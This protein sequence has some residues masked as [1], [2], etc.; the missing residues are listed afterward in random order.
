MAKAQQEETY[1]CDQL[2]MIQLH[3]KQMRQHDIPAAF[4]EVVRFA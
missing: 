4:P 3:S 1:Q 2:H